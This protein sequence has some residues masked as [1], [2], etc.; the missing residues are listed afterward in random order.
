MKFGAYLVL[1]GLIFG[2]GVIFG[3]NF[4]LVSYVG[5][6]SWRELIFG[7]LILGILRNCSVKLF[8]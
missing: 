2:G 8:Q 6:Y 4:V 5:L 1:R 3:A 7:G